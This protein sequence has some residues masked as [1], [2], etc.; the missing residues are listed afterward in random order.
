MILTFAIAY[1]GLTS[2]RAVEM[3]LERLLALHNAGRATVE[4]IACRAELTTFFEQDGKVVPDGCSGEF[5]YDVGAL[6]ARIFERGE[7]VVYVWRDG[8]AWC[9][10]TS[11][12]GTGALK[13]R[14]DR[15]FKRC[16]PFIQGLLQLQGFGELENYSLEDF[17]ARAKRVDAPRKV[18][19]EHGVEVWS[20]RL[21]FQ[22]DWG[23]Y[24]AEIEL[25]PKFNFLVRRNT[26]SVLSTG[27]KRE[28]VVTSFAEVAP[29]VYFPEEAEIHANHF[30]TMKRIG[31]TR[32]TDIRVPD[33]YPSG[34]FAL[35]IPSGCIVVDRVERKS[36]KANAD[37]QP[38]SEVSPLADDIHPAPLLERTSIASTSAAEGEPVALHRWVAFGSVA[39]MA[40]AFLFAVLRLRWRAAS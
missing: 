38:I 27:R 39:L 19:N 11:P 10:S 5:F 14:V 3:P 13:N 22:Q 31:I 34:F 20:L 28:V 26:L 18:K 37:W 2:L 21:V 23:S 30:G 24:E 29:G 36:Y 17:V 33:P 8:I 6:R 35:S 9:L 40:L 7:D 15:S 25:D 1:A 32:I 4:R 16:D 12:V